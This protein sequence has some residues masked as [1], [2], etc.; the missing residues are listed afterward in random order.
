VSI[1]SSLNSLKDIP[2]EDT[3][4]LSQMGTATKQSNPKL[5][6]GQQQHPQTMVNKSLRSPPFQMHS[7]MSDLVLPNLDSRLDQFESEHK[8]HSFRNTPGISMTNDPKHHRNQSYYGLNSVQSLNESVDYSKM[9]VMSIRDFRQKKLW[10]EE[11]HGKMRIF[12]YLHNDSQE[13]LGVKSIIEQGLYTR[14]SMMPQ[15]P[16]VDFEESQS[17]SRSRFLANASFL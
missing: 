5:A 14:K 10:E 3:Q 15:Q 6:G 4:G 11:P 1:L 8:M 17:Q 13:R 7:K 16:S 9:K 12:D 2:E